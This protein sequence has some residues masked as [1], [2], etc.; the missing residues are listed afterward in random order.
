MSR[1]GEEIINRLHIDCSLHNPSNPARKVIDNT[2]GEWLTNFDDFDLFS[3]VFVND[4]TGKYL[5]LIG[6]DYNIKR[7]LDESDDD[8]RQRIILESLGHLTVNYLLEVYNLELYTYVP[9][10][11]VEDNTLT[12]DN[13]YINSNGFMTVAS[14]E[15]KAVL[16]KKFVIG[17][18]LHWLT[19]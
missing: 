7:R 4:A 3:Q 18:G 16:E 11:S 19:L 2:I 10:F 8:Y 6:R 17:E 15:I 5:D 14:D 9:S 12:S 1:F 13:P